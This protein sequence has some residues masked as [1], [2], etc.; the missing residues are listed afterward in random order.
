[1]AP[2]SFYQHVPLPIRRLSNRASILPTRGSEFAAGVDLC[3]AEATLI[4]S[5]GRAIVNTDLAIACPRGT[6]ARIAPRSGLARNH[7]IDVGAGVIDADYRGPIGVLLFNFGD[8]DF[9]ARPGDR[10]A[11]LILERI[12]LPDVVLVENLP[13][14]G[15]RGAAGFGST[16][17]SADPA[18]HRDA[19]TQQD[20]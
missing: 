15:Q 1:M 3:A 7:G 11:Q 12:I 5:G 14:L 2:I 19:G 8:S 10:I 17:L 13:A 18:A 4:L 9:H 6:Y 20:I 16:P